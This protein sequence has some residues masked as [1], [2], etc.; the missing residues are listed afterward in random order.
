MMVVRLRASAAIVQ[1]VTG[2][3]G[4][5]LGQR[6]FAVSYDTSRDEF[7]VDLTFRTLSLGLSP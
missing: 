1:S 4:G 2:M 3:L 5:G 7:N 6:R